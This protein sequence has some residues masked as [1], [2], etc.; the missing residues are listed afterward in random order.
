MRISEVITALPAITALSGTPLRQ[1]LQQVGKQRVQQAKQREQAARQ[2][3]QL[4]QQRD[5]EWR[6]RHHQTVRKAANLQGKP[7]RNAVR[8]K[9]RANTRQA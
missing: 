1:H 8:A 9:G 2:Q 6:K 5:A 3:K 7:S 4:Q